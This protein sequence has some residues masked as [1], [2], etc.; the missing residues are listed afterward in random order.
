MSETQKSNR[1]L[2]RESGSILYRIATCCASR[3]L[4]HYHEVK[5]NCLTIAISFA[6]SFQRALRGRMFCQ[7]FCCPRPVELSIVYRLRLSIVALP[8]FT[9]RAAMIHRVKPT[10]TSE[11]ASQFGCF[12][13]VNDKQSL[14]QPLT[15]VAHPYKMMQLRQLMRRER[16]V[17]AIVHY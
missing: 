4:V 2:I 17:Q 1:W 10:V 6:A 8:G 14:L 11:S 5:T 3:P 7:L 15:D 12:A 9:T 13:R 16:I